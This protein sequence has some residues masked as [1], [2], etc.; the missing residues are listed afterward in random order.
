MARIVETDPATVS[1]IAEADECDRQQQA[2]DVV[3]DLLGLHSSDLDEKMTVI[4][5]GHLFD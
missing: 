4:P 3:E 2:F 1:G 5:V